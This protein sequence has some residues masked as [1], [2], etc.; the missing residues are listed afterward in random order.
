MGADSFMAMVGL[1]FPVSREEVD[2]MEW[3]DDPRQVAAEKAGLEAWFGSSGD[4]GP[5]WLLVGRPLGWLRK[6]HEY[7]HSIDGSLLAEE[8]EKAAEAL[9]SVGFLDPP[10]LLLEFQPD[11]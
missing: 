9:R 10:R 11:Y 8:M 3:V 1:R 4:G 7:S 2:A 5:Y 6:E